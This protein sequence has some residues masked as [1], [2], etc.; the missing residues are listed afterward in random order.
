MAAIKLECMADSTSG[1]PAGFVGICNQRPSAKKPMRHLE[2]DNLC[3]ITIANTKC[4]LV[5][6]YDQ[7]KYHRVWGLPASMPRSELLSY[8]LFG[9]PRQ[10][11]TSEVRL[12]S[13]DSE[14]ARR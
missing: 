14:T 10:A 13:I 4:H 6:A 5:G 8:F 12:P 7:L 11:E 2:Q 1:Y 3:F 9:C